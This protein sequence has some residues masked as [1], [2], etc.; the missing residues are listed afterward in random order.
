[1][2]PPLEDGSTQL[3]IQGELDGALLDFLKHS[4]PVIVL[5]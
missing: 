2:I 5:R 4:S 3:F 1:L